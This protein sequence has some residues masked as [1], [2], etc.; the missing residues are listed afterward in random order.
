MIF[1]LSNFSFVIS[2]AAL[3][4]TTLGSSVK[5]FSNFA[6]VVWYE[7]DSKNENPAAHNRSSYLLKGLGYTVLSTCSFSLMLYLMKTSLLQTT[8]LEE[9][10]QEHLICR[11]N[12]FSLNLHELSFRL[13][14]IPSIDQFC[15]KYFIARGAFDDFLNSNEKDSTSTFYWVE[16]IEPYFNFHGN[17]NATFTAVYSLIETSLSNCNQEMTSIK[18]TQSFWVEFCNNL[19]DMNPNRKSILAIQTYT[20]KINNLKNNLDI[21]NNQF[22]KSYH[23]QRC[24]RL[25]FNNDNSYFDYEFKTEVCKQDVFE[26]KSLCN[27][28]I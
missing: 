23:P 25:F 21:L 13:Q 24:Q 2:T 16:N 14:S 7:P 15:R 4:V 18:K 26:K 9:G 3:G 5:I 22:W 27:K 10:N 28:K 17:I 19:I 11:K 8:S 6:H 1:N 20:D 12:W